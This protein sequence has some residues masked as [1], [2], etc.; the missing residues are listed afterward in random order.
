MDQWPHEPFPGK[1]HHISSVFALVVAFNFW[2]VSFLSTKGL[3]NSTCHGAGASVMLGLRHEHASADAAWL[4][5][6]GHRVFSQHPQPLLVLPQLLQQQHQL[7]ALPFVP[8]FLQTSL[9]GGR[10]YFPFAEAAQQGSTEPFPERETGVHRTS[11]AHR[12]VR[13]CHMACRWLGHA[14]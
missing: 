11:E 2:V 12:H 5:C 8:L 14:I 1:H 4:F 6:C 3:F 10:Q 9:V 13:W 7:P